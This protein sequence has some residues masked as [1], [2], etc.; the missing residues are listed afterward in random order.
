METIQSKDNKL[1]KHGKK[2]NVRKYRQESNEFMVEGIRFVEEAADSDANIKYCLYSEHLS[3][4]RVY[5][6]IKRMEDRKVKTFKV[7]DGLIDDICETATPQG[8]VAVVERKEYRLNDVLKNGNLFIVV[9]RIQ[10]PGNLGT[11]IRTAHAAKVD[12]IIITEGTVD[13]YGPK[14]LRSTMGS[15]FHVPVITSEELTGPIENLKKEGFTVFA[16]SLAG[17]T[18]YYTEMYGGKTAIIIGNEANGID[19]QVLEKADRLIKIPMPGNAESL[20]AAVACG[21]LLFE[22]AR[23]RAAVDNR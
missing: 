13:P 22:V 12:G 23:Q 2:L 5:N 9:D 21:I 7:K 19:A 18:A 3:G 8:I 10:D 4:D 17:S 14:V 20:N 11:I 15:I 16:S 6:I 1:L